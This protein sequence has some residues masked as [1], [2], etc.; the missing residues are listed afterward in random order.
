MS[1]EIESFPFST[2]PFPPLSTGTILDRELGGGLVEGGLNV[3]CGPAGCGKTTLLEAIVEASGI[4]GYAADPYSSSNPQAWERMR[5][6]GDVMALL[7]EKTELVVL[8]DLTRVGTFLDTT[9]VTAIAAFLSAARSKGITLLVSVPSVGDL[10]MSWLRRADLVIGLDATHRAA[11]GSFKMS[12]ALLKH[13]T[14][15]PGELPPMVA[16][17]HPD[18][19]PYLKWA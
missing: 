11:D 13:R 1:T 8:D 10:E 7:D 19:R 18:K 15:E 4:T 6:L 5:S 17:R 16:G 3:V 2:E 12:A 9:S 14:R